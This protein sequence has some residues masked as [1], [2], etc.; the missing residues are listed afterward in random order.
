MHARML[1]FCPK[2][3]VGHRS[4]VM[5]NVPS[6]L[7]NVWEKTIYS[8]AGRARDQRETLQFDTEA[9][10]AYIAYC[11]AIEKRLRGDLDGWIGRWAKKLCGNAVRLAG[12]MALMEEEDYV[13]LEHWQ[14]AEKMMEEYFIPHARY[15]FGGEDSLLSDNARL[16]W[17]KLDED[18]FKESEFWA[19]RGRYIFKK[20]DEYLEAL[21][22]LQVR[23]YIHPSEE[24]DVYYGSGRRPSIKWELNP[25]YTN[26]KK[27]MVEV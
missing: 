10:N 25:E 21:T 4:V 16:L 3:L 12:L 8:L 22:E 15:V 13:Q 1:Y 18:A 11:E 27:A 20:H 26:N 7:K 9:E 19:R 14:A 17:R 6:K 23:G 5:K 2:S 24:Q